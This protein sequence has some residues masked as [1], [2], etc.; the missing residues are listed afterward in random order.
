MTHG[1]TWITETNP[2]AKNWG[3]GFKLPETM[4]LESIELIMV[5]QAA[6]TDKAGTIIVKGFDSPQPV[7]APVLNALEL[8]DMLSQ[9]PHNTESIESGHNVLT[10]QAVFFD[11]DQPSAWGYKDTDIAGKIMEAGTLIAWDYFPVI[12]GDPSVFT[13][14]IKINGIVGRKAG[15]RGKTYSFL[16][17]TNIL[18]Y[19]DWA[20]G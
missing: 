5:G 1:K 11:I 2:D 3:D 14:V 12:T 13:L 9:T 18:D 19:N 10:E 20:G 4:M 8:G 6:T 17:G 7:F 15:S 16:E